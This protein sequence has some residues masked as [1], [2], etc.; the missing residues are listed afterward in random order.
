MFYEFKDSDVGAHT[1]VFPTLTL[2]SMNLFGAA[3]GWGKGGTKRFPPSLK[4]VSYTTS[5]KLGTVIPYQK[6][7]QKI[8]KSRD[9][10]LEFC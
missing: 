1:L 7:I 5:M 10:P 3:H 8:H 2:F 4:S 9:T 6:K